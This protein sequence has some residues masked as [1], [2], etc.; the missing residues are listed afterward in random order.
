MAEEANTQPVSNVTHVPPLQDNKQ[1]LLVT[2]RAKIIWPTGLPRR[3]GFFLIQEQ[4]ALS[5]RTGWLYSYDF[6]VVKITVR[7]RE[8]LESAQPV[9]AAT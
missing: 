7:Y 6:R 5:S 1:V 2:F 3:L 9:H 8:M 4:L